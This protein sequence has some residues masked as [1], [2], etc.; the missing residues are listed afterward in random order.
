MVL[1]P[2]RSH[3]VG[4]PRCQVEWTSLSVLCL[5]AARPHPPTLKLSASHVKNAQHFK[6]TIQL[7]V[8]S[9]LTHSSL[10]PCHLHLG[11]LGDDWDTRT[12]YD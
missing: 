12:L 5:S 11:T 6:I 8:S 3:V 10:Q 1:N 7:G 4:R 9:L 2:E